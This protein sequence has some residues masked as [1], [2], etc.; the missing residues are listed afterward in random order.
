[1]VRDVYT[2]DIEYRLPS[3]NGKGE[4]VHQSKT[5][6]LSDYL[7]WRGLFISVVELHCMTLRTLGL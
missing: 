7:T 1:M 6:R 5:I 2:V 4:L 3:G